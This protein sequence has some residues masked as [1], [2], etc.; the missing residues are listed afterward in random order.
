RRRAESLA[1]QVLDQCERDHSFK[2][3]DFNRLA[4]PRTL[5]LVERHGDRVSDD[6]ADGL[7]GE[8]SVD[9]SRGSEEHTSELQSLPKLVCRVLRRPAPSRLVPYTT[10]FRSPTPG[11][12]SRPPGARSV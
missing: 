1:R 6:A 9:V 4:A 12:K 2:H 8:D 10:L 3:R 11:R 5:A 7:V